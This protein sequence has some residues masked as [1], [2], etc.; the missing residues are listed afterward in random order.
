MLTDFAKEK[1]VYAA[2]LTV[3]QHGLQSTV[4]IGPKQLIQWL[5]ESGPAVGEAERAK[6]LE[7]NRQEAEQIIAGVLGMM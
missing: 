5:I 7:D 3:E 4:Q 2:R 6:E 1:L